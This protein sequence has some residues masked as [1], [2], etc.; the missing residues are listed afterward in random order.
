MA[1]PSDT[2]PQPAHAMMPVLPSM[3]LTE[4]ESVAGQ[5]WTNPMQPGYPQPYGFGYAAHQYPQQPYHYGAHKAYPQ[6]SPYQPNYTFSTVPQTYNHTHPSSSA[7]TELYPPAS[8]PPFNGGTI[9]PSAFSSWHNEV[10]RDMSSELASGVDED[11]LTERRHS[12]SSAG[13]KWD[14]KGS[15][16]SI[17]ISDNGSDYIDTATPV[18]KKTKK[19]RAAPVPAKISEVVEGDITYTTDCEVKQTSTV[20]FNLS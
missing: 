10:R 19:A 16:A 5:Y 3:R 4:S 6:Y 18:R 9:Q 7:S 20:G 8:A 1:N 12:V 17:V 15:P 2:V 11:R 13:E 14:I